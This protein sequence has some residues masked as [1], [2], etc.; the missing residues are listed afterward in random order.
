MRRSFC[1][2]VLIPMLLVLAGC[3]S[4][5]TEGTADLAG[6]AG[7][8]TASAVTRNAATAAANGYYDDISNLYLDTLTLSQGYPPMELSCQ[9]PQSRYRRHMT[10]P[11][12]PPIPGPSPPKPAPS[13][14]FRTFPG[15]AL[16]APKYVPTAPASAPPARHPAAA[17]RPAD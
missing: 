4:L 5:L 6:I 15:S 2:P 14:S 16:R 10:P 8:A 12:A 9:A 11:A 17:T 7:A 13:T 3:G 1:L